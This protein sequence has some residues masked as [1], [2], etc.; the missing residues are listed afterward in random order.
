MSADSF[1]TRRVAATR[2]LHDSCSLFIETRSGGNAL[3]C[4]AFVPTDESLKHYL[5]NFFPSDVAAQP[6]GATGTIA[7][8]FQAGALVAGVLNLWKGGDG[9]LPL[10]EHE[11]VLG[12]SHRVSSWP[13]PAIDPVS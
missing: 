12:L 13:T 9:T 2:A 5:D 3:L 8:G 7:I 11:V 6:C 1:E 4:H 10:N